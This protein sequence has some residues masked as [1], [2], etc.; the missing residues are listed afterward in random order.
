MKKTKLMEQNPNYSFSLVD[1]LDLILK[2]NKGKYIDMSLNLLKNKFKNTD[3]DFNDMKYWL[4]KDYDIETSKIE[5]LSNERLYFLSRLLDNFICREDARLLNKF[6]ELNERN[7]IEKK[8]VT[9]LKTFDELILEISKAEIK[10]WEKEMSKDV[11]KIYE[12][13]E[14]ILIKP[15][16]WLSSRKYGSSTKWCTAMVKTPEYFI[17]YTKEGILIYCLNK[18]NG[19]HVAVY[20]ELI[21]HNELSFW[22]LLDKRIDSMEANLSLEVL[23]VI[24]QTISE[25]KSNSELLSLEQKQKEQEFIIQWELENE[26]KKISLSTIGDYPELE[27]IPNEPESINRA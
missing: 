6:I 15:L 26:V 9:S 10:L 24:R 19:N 1:I 22:D 17:R 8:D 16:T 18:K 12:D 21:D 5:N 7:L 13:E 11:I 23:N 2:N 27:E 3:I 14:W 20:K 25:T 4:N